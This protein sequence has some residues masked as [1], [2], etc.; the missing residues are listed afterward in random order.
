[1]RPPLWPQRLRTGISGWSASNTRN[2]SLFH[3]QMCCI[4][5]PNPKKF[6]PTEP[7]RNVV[8]NVANPDVLGPPGSRSP[9]YGPGS[10]FFYNQAKIEKK[11]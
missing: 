10:G 3:E 2:N 4:Y 7:Y 5:N 11:P 1:M 9:R 8:K 6:R